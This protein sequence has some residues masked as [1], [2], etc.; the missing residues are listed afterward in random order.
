LL[1]CLWLCSH[2]ASLLIIVDP[3]IVLISGAQNFQSAC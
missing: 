2:S 3:M 1:E